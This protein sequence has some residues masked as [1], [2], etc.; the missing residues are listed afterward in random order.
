MSSNPANDWGVIDL[1]MLVAASG[2]RTFYL[3]AEES[4][5]FAP[6]PII[7]GFLLGTA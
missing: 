1:A 2:N 5:R 7:G 6:V 4:R 3:N